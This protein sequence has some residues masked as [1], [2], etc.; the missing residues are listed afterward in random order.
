VPYKGSVHS[1]EPKNR[2]QRRYRKKYKLTLVKRR[3][4]TNL[5][6]DNGHFGENNKKSI[7]FACGLDIT[8]SCL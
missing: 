4:H 1:S 8:F 7:K 2:N 3:T 6:Q 5:F